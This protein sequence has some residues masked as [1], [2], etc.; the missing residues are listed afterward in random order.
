MH[1]DRKYL[2]RSTKYVRRLEHGVRNRQPTV[3]QLCSSKLFRCTMDLPVFV[4]VVCSGYF[5]TTK[6]KLDLQRQDFAETRVPSWRWFDDENA[7]WALL[8]PGV[9]FIVCG[10]CGKFS[11]TSIGLSERCCPQKDLFH[12]WTIL[13]RRFEQVL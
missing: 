1:D 10:C 2:P 8:C 7:L 6:N 4:G 9:V 5:L 12:E 11:R 3:L 13:G